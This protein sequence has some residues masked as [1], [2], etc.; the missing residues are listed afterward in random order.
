MTIVVDLLGPLRMTAGGSEVRLGGPGRRTVVALLALQPGA[1]VSVDRLVDAVWDDH[2]P[3]TAVTKLQGHICGLRR[4]ISRLG[5][6]AAAVL[7]TTSPG[8]LLSDRL[9]STDLTEFERL[10]RVAAQSSDAR[11]TG[12]RVALLEQ[13]LGLWRGTACSDVRSTRIV[14]AAATLDDRRARVQESLAEARLHLGDV[15][16]ALDE[17]HR[18]VLEQPLRERAWEM[19][20]RC[21]IARRDTA[22]ALAAY[23]QVSQLLAT[24]LGVPPGRQLRTLAA[25]LGAVGALVTR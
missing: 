9:V 12:Q 18:L 20:M 7:Q 13:A 10:S 19:V 16:T 1:V 15:D 17:M 22:A 11:D 21:H 6:D 3:V 14:A 5:Y 2:P 4:E 8:Y 23:H 24:E 25:D